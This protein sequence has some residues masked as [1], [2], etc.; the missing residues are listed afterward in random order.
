[1]RLARQQ[2][3]RAYRRLLR[4]Q[5]GLQEIEQIPECRTQ[6]P[7]GDDR[8]EVPMFRERATGMRIEQS[9][10]VEAG[11][12]ETQWRQQFVLQ[13]CHEAAIAAAKRLTDEA[14]LQWRITR[15]GTAVQPV[16]REQPVKLRFAEV[17]IGI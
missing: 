17:R 13:Q 14:V 7:A 10:V 11:M 8:A 5:I 3:C 9:V 4:T 2:Q 6:A 15:G 12:F 16:I 1:M